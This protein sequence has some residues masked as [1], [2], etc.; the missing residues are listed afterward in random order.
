MSESSRPSPRPH[1]PG[2]ITKQHS[3]GRQRVISSCLTCRRRKV[4]CDHI[5]P[6][7]GACTRGNHACIYA[8]DP[9]LGPAA[10][11]GGTRISK[12]ASSNVKLSK[13]SDVQARL[14]RLES[15]L[16]KAVSG[17][18]QPQQPLLHHGSEDHVHLS[19]FSPSAASQSSQ[20]AG[21]SSDD[22]DGTLLLDG[23]QSKFVSSLHYALLADEVYDT[24]AYFQRF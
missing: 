11:S 4:K 10:G 5:H 15:L 14:D 2:T 18:A 13:T 24:I 20:G 19:E 21:I 12:A 6:V 7:C 23:G 8:S 3:G 9:M 17:H 1:S 22:H 16:Q